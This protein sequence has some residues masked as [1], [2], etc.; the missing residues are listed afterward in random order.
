MGKEKGKGGP[1]KGPGRGPGGGPP[2]GGPGRGPGIHYMV[3]RKKPQGQT[4]QAAPRYQPGRGK[5]DH[6]KIIGL[7][8]ANRGN[9]PTVINNKNP[10]K[11]LAVMPP[12][13]SIEQSAV[14][15]PKKVLH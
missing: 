2:K 1:P 5:I 8:S 14:M 15:P 3:I 13:R 6:K 10:P 12:K 11:K 7:I 4:A 9:V